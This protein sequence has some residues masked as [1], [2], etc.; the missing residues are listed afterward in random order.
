MRNNSIFGDLFAVHDNSLNFIKL[1]ISRL[2][3]VNP[4]VVSCPDILLKMGDPMRIISA[5]NHKSCAQSY[6]RQVCRASSNQVFCERG[7]L[8]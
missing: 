3:L 8:L 7:R 6:R 4:P 2:W 5:V 1:E